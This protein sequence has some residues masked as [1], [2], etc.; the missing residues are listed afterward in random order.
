MFDLP[1]SYKMKKK[2]PQKDYLSME[3]KP[4]TRKKVKDTVISFHFNLSD[5][6]CKY[7]TFGR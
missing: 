5:N 3:F 1:E 2:I 7:A 6:R 4:A